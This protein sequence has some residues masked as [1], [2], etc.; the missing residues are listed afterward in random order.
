M[1][2]GAEGVERLVSDS[3]FPSPQTLAPS[4]RPKPSKGRGSVLSFEHKAPGCC[5]CPD[6]CDLRLARR[7]RQGIYGGRW[8]NPFVAGG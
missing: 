2:V 3:R 1:C 7:V 5:D 8:K 4:S 6:G